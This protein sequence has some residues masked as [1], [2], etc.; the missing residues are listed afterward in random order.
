MHI[1]NGRK[2]V[3]DSGVKLFRSNF[4][5]FLLIFP[6]RQR[7]WATRAAVVAVVHWSGRYVRQTLRFPF[8]LYV[9]SLIELS[10]RIKASQRD[11]LEIYFKERTEYLPSEFLLFF[12][13]AALSRWSNRVCHGSP[14]EYTNEKRSEDEERKAQIG[15]KDRS[16]A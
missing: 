14:K 10:S 2:H 11:I 16:T 9:Y 12:F 7:E 5:R 3:R 13:S 6:R 8:S 4:F 1:H 15:M